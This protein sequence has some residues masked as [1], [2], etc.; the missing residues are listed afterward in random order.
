M[1][2]VQEVP[3]E[4]A[5]RMQGGLLVLLLW[6]LLLMIFV[7]SWK[8]GLPRWQALC[9]RGREPEPSDDHV[10]EEKGRTTSGMGGTEGLWGP[11]AGTCVPPRGRLP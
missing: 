5:F 10:E 11:L 6:L 9:F 4:V 3:Q 2:S 1:P 7:K 8:A